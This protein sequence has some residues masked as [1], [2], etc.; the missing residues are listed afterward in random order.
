[1]PDYK[2]GNIYTVR[3]KTDDTLIYVGCTTQSLS[4]RM[5]KHKHDSM[6]R[7]NI[8]FYQHIDDWDNWYIELYEN[9]A[10]ENKEQLNKREGEIIREIGTINKQ[11]AGRTHQEWYKDNKEKVLKQRKDNY[12]NNKDKIL[13]SQKEYANKNKDKIKEY[14]KEYG[15]KNKE[16][17]AEANKEYQQNNKDKFKEYL[18]QY[19]EDNKQKIAEQ[20]KKKYY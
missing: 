15:Q 14:K 5:A 7:P 6:K 13:Q 8:C 9:Y 1:M 11:I 18:K 20:M 3:C 17:L 2:Q 4:E 10:C 16:K 12:D 19:R